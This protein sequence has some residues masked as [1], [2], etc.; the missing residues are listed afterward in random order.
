MRAREGGGSRGSLWVRG[1]DT[2]GIAEKHAQLHR[3]SSLHM[4]APCMHAYAMCAKS[5]HTWGTQILSGI[6]LWRLVS[7]S[8]V[9]RETDGTTSP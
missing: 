5:M 1:D 9:W 4:A 7:K 6:M 2:H 8:G 3:S